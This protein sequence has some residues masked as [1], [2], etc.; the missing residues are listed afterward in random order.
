MR[1]ALRKEGPATANAM[2]EPFHVVEHASRPLDQSD[3]AAVRDRQASYVARRLGLSAERARL[4][5][6]FAFGGGAA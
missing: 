3:T 1:A 5:A 4:V 6:P 2:S